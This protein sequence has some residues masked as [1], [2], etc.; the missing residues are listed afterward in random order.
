MNKTLSD[1]IIYIVWHATRISGGL[2]TLALVKFLYLAD[3]FNAEDT[4]GDTLTKLPWI[5]Y[6]YGP[7]CTESYRAIDDA[8]KL[9]IICQKTYESKFDDDK[10]SRW[11]FCTSSDEPQVNIPTYVELRLP[12][13]IKQFKDNR[14]LMDYVYFKTPPMENPNEKELL[15]FSMVRKFVPEQPIETKKLSAKNAKKALELI[16]NMKVIRAQ[17]NIYQSASIKPVYDSNY[18]LFETALDEHSDA[19][20]LKGRMHFFD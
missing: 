20:Q 12:S 7:Y 11:F 18:Y 16:R 1:L 8:V 13:A 14:D 10:V 9:G 6:H 2:S 15:D 19:P 3:I 5:F 4:K 17:N